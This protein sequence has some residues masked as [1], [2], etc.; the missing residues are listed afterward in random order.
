MAG[1]AGG[2]TS[3][4]ANGRASTAP[5]VALARRAVAP[6]LRDPGPPVGRQFLGL[7]FEAADLGLLARATERGN[8]VALLRSL[9]PGVLRLGGSSADAFAAWAPAPAARPAWATATVT[10]A[11]LASLARLATATGWG[12]LLTVNLGHYDPAA[13]AAEV[14]AARAALGARLLAVEIGN[15]PEHF[16]GHGLR[17]ATWTS[18]AY[19]VEV[20]A[21]R[22]AIARAAPGV[23]L[24]GP[25]AVSLAGEPRLGPARGDLG[26]PGTAHRALLP[27]RAVRLVRAFDRRP[28]RRGSAP[29]RDADAD[30]RGRRVQAHRDTAA[31]R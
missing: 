17:D 7:S 24:A 12:V 9:G 28:A 20:D 14:S 19:R 31:P 21:Y 25:D 1:C 6:G 10:P 3:S 23:A 13:A 8:L 4:S 18:R 5:P 2:G 16:V 11:D 15:E 22:A 27:A 26:A 29:S 30:A